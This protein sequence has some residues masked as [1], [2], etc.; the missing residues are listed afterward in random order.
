MSE[1]FSFRCLTGF[2]FFFF[3]LSFFAV[4]VIVSFFCQ[5]K[6]N[7]RTFYFHISKVYK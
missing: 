2:F 4:V 5:V 1:L 7:I 6:F 3:L